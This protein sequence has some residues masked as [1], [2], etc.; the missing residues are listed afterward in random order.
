[1]CPWPHGTYFGKDFL[2]L[3]LYKEGVGSFGRQWVP[4]PGL[5]VGGILGV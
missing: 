1:M 3:E 2:T 5:P 4:C